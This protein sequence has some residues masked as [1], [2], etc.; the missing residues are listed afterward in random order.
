MNF[1]VS[2]EKSIKGSYRFQVISSFES[3][4]NGSLAE[5]F[6]RCRHVAETT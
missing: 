4:E 6:G 1:A 3:R 5:L 2:E